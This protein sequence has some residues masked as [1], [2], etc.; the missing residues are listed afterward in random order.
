VGGGRQG[1]RRS[2]WGLREKRKR[3]EGM[4]SEGAEQVSCGPRQSRG[5]KDRDTV[6]WVGPGGKGV[7]LGR[8]GGAWRAGQGLGRRTV[9]NGSEPGDPRLGLCRHR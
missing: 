1:R 2:E 6:E 5:R 7:G 4:E 3:A 9:R 8:E